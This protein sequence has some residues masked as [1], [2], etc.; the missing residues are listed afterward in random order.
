MRK[1]Y[2]AAFKAGIVQE[3]LREDK[4]ITQI[5]SAHGVHPNPSAALRA[6]SGS[7]ETRASTGASRRRRTGASTGVSTGASTRRR[8]DFSTGASTGAS[9]GPATGAV[10]DEW[11]RQLTLSSVLA[12]GR[13]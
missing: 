1:H 12:T 8:F 7:T 6:G 13:K 2:T 11:A 10:R 5:A 9:T 3:V 4:L